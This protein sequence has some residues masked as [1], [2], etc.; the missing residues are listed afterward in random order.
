MGLVVDVLRQFSGVSKASRKPRINGRRS[1]HH[2]AAEI[3]EFGEFAF[4]PGAQRLSGDAGEIALPRRAMAVLQTLLEADGDLVERRALE[5]AVW[6]DTAVTDALL[7]EAVSL[8][9]R[10][11]G[12]DPSRPRYVQTV[13]RRG[14]RWVCRLRTR[15]RSGLTSGWW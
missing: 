4:D 11:L 10:A 3:L 6:G 9:R 5:Q 8:V 2:R 14:Y 13:H 15:A 1:A 12:D 7:T